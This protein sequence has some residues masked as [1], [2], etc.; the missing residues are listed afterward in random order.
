MPAPSG[1]HTFVCP[2]STDPDRLAAA[3]GEPA[4][5]D[6]LDRIEDS[7]GGA[8][9]QVI[10]RVDRLELSK[11][12]LRGF[13]A[14]EELL[15]QVPAHRERVVFVALAYPTRQGLPEYLAYQDEVE[16]TV[17]RINERWGTPG[18]TP[19][20]L[21]VEDDYPRSLAALTRSDVL[22]INPV[23]DG[24]NLVAKEG[25]LINTRDGVLALS[26]EAGAFDE[27]A[28][29]ALEVNPFDVTG[30]ASVL[31]RAL[32]M[33]PGERRVRA[34]LLREAIVS[35]SPSGWLDRQLAA[36]RST[37]RAGRRLLLR[38]SCRQR[39]VSQPREQLPCGLGSPHGQV[40]ERGHLGCG[41]VVDDRHGHPLPTVCRRPV[42]ELGEGGQVAEVVAQ[43]ASRRAGRGQ[44]PEHRSL[45]DRQGWPQL[46]RAAARVCHQPG[47]FCLGANPIGRPPGGGRGATPVDGHRQ[48]LALHP[49]PLGSVGPE[50]CGHLGDHRTPGRCGGLDHHATAR[51]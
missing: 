1:P 27:L 7:V 17:A 8:D 28:D 36:A 23:R 45:V 26:R 39:G 9:R 46:E 5:G 12:L 37:G 24:L 3:A 32:A 40:G 30:T 38:P 11:N 44:A 14:Y 29:G 47:A 42:G 49:G 48:L 15:A 25:P 16:T 50:A 19:I 10:V 41:L 43:V 22:L 34:K 13:W 18:W 2:L 51:G 33:D 21:E 35:R 6:A 31:A 20:V 4:V